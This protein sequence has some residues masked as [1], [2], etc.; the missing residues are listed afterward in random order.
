MP[1][2]NVIDIRRYCYFE[3]ILIFF[4]FKKKLLGLMKLTG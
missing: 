1:E 3:L 2:I 4:I